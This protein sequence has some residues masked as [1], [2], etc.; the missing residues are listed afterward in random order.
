MPRCQL[1][2]NMNLSIVHRSFTYKYLLFFTFFFNGKIWDLVVLSLAQLSC[3]K[4]YLR[5]IC[6]VF[7]V[8]RRTQT[9][10][11]GIRCHNSRV[12]TATSYV[13]ADEAV[14]PQCG[15]CRTGTCASGIL[16]R[17]NTYH[18]FMHGTR[19]S[20]DS[21]H[22]LTGKQRQVIT[23]LLEFT[24]KIRCCAGSE[25]AAPHITGTG[26]DTSYWVITELHFTRSPIV[27]VHFDGPVARAESRAHRTTKCGGA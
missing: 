13:E 23:S 16:S 7:I 12:N 17:T 24:V 1:K 2:T 3:C 26:T 27:R 6:E 9:Q 20:C 19:N 21:P 11:L 10:R 22:H 8:C 15:S 14:A 25:S 4:L 5:E 18:N